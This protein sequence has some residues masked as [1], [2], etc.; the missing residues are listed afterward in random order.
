MPL[1]YFFYLRTVHLL[2]ELENANKKQKYFPMDYLGDGK[3]RKNGKT[4]RFDCF[5]N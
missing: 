3:D 1:Q 2:T 5:V 4:P